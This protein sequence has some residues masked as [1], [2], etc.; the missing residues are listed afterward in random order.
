LESSTLLPGLTKE[1]V[2]MSPMVPPK[3]APPTAIL[4]DLYWS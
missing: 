4:R 3:P 2:V 1:L